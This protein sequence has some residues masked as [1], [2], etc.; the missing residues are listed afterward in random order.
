MS[1]VD[2]G[3]EV[4]EVKVTVYYQS[5]AESREFKGFEAVKDVLGWAIEVF[6]VDGSLA[7][8]LVLVRHGQKEELREQ[9]PIGPLVGKEGELRLDLVR[10]DIANGS[11]W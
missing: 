11:C 8:E 5:G 1:K 6:K 9:D 2:E 10:G 7:T 3:K 4:V